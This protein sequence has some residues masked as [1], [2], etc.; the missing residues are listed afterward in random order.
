MQ[1]YCAVTGACL[2]VKREKYLAVGGLDEKNLA[3]AFNDIDFCLKLRAA[4]Y[5]NIWTP[6]AQLYHYESY[7]RGSDA[8]ADKIERYT[9]EADYMRKRWA[10]ELKEDPYYNP[11]FRRDQ[12]CFEL[13]W[14]P[15]H[16]D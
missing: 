4:G 5:Q 3:V 1:E 11:S 12:N 7:T 16:E 15:F 9:V 2:A 13:A 14:P 8:A 6:Y 10:K